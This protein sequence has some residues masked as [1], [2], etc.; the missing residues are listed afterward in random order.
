MKTLQYCSVCKAEFDME[1]VPTADGDDDGV[2]WLQCPQCRGF[3]PKIR[4]SLDAAAGGG[5]ARVADEAEVEETPETEP[6]A[7]PEAAAP[8]PAAAAAELAEAVARD[9]DEALAGMD[10]DKAVTYRPWSVYAEGDVLHH[11]AW[12][13]YGVVVAKETIP[14]NRSVVMVRFAKHG[15]VR[16][17]EQDGSGR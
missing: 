12:D 9:A 4:S 10:V 17:I 15:T 6:D 1:V 3:L 14:G 16:L 8:D 13:D 11:L 2:V 7:K 5:D